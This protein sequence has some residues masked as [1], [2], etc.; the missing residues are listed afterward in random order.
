MSQAISRQQDAYVPECPGRG[1]S[2]PRDGRGYP[3][4]AAIE[5]A[6]LTLAGFAAAFGRARRAEA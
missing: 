3:D 2:W 5:E 4:A 6:G 1:R